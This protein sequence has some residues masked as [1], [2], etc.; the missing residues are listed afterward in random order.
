MRS[1]LPSVS[2]A[3]HMYS[4]TGGRLQDPHQVGIDPLTTVKHDIRQLAFFEKYPSFQTIF[5]R[6]VNGD[7]TMFRDA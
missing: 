3:V 5:S 4:Q 6:L 1:V 2:D 7:S